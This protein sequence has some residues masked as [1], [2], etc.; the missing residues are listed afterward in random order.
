MKY[1]M[2]VLS[3]ALVGCSESEY[4]EFNKSSGD[5]DSYT[6]IGESSHV[7]Y[8]DSEC[9]QYGFNSDFRFGYDS[10]N[11]YQEDPRKSSENVK[12]YYILDG[13]NCLKVIDSLTLFH[14]VKR[15]HV[16][17]MFYINGVLYSNKPASHKYI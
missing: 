8:F 6:I 12:F 2:M 16:T 4:I 13:E 1:L 14:A 9:S 10:K 17:G 11:T 5:F 3:L 15:K 7:V